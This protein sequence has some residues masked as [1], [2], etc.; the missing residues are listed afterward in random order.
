[1]KADTSSRDI[2]TGRWGID[3][4][5]LQLSARPPPA[6]PGSGRLDD[7]LMAGFMAGRNPLEPARARRRHHVRT[8]PHAHVPNTPIS[9]SARL[10][11]VSAYCRWLLGS[12]RLVWPPFGQPP[13]VGAASAST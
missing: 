5:A 6:R 11:H 4:C 2:L 13:G 10:N 9:V 8:R 7:K 1:M 3:C 12:V